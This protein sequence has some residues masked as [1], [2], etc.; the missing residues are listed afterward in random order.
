MQS[1]NVS[2]QLIGLLTFLGGVGLLLLTF[3]LAYE[4]FQ[5]PPAQVLGF[6]EEEVLDVNN[7]GRSAMAL[8]FRVIV[9][10]LMSV[11]GSVIAN[12]GIRLYQA[13][14]GE[15]KPAKVEEPTPSTPV[16]TEPKEEEGAK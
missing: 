10:L 14:L 15:I 13:A 6:K 1:R 11:L 8:L 5:M 2:G 9:L 12:R 16:V 7:A 3:K 4:L